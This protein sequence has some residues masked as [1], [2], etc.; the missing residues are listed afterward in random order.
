MKKWLSLAENVLNLVTKM[1]N[2]WNNNISNRSEITKVRKRQT[3]ISA[4][5]TNDHK[6]ITRAKKISS[7]MK[8]CN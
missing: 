6:Y 8:S 4:T 7:Q 5:R 2:N 1:N 3:A